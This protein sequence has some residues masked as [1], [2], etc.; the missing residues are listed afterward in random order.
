MRKS[1]TKV[2]VI[3]TI[4][5]MLVVGL[6]IYIVTD[7]LLVKEDNKATRSNTETTSNE[8]T[9]QQ[10]K[11]EETENIETNTNTNTSSIPTEEE[12]KKLMITYIKTKFPSA[13]DYRINS[14]SIENN[15]KEFK[16]MI[17][18]NQE[19]VLAYVDYDLIRDG[20]G[21]TK[22]QGFVKSNQAHC[23]LVKD[24]NGSYYVEKCGSGW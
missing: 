23:I 3:I 24:S 22:E 11:E 20:N 19:H 9:P 4:L 16:E 18:E 8:K 21:F 2:A 15:T 1:D 6:L 12:V 10:E 5:V 7:K 17:N 14:I 13:I